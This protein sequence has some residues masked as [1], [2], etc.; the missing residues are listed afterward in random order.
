GT[1][2]SGTL[3]CGG[4]TAN[5]TSLFN[6]ALGATN[7]ANNGMFRVNGNL[8]LD[9]TLSLTDLGGMGV[10]VYTN[11][12]Y[13]GTL[14]SNGLAISGGPMGS[15][16]VV[17]TGTPHYVLM[18]VL[19]GSL[20]P[21][22]GDGVPMDSVSPLALSW[23]EMVGAT[24][25]DV[26]L[27]TASNEVFSATTSTA[28]IYQGRTNALTLNVANLLP[29]TT[30][31]W[32]ADGW[33]ANGTVT[34]GAVWS[35]TTGAAMADLMQDTWVATDA[36]NRT[37]PGVAECGSPRT[38]QPIGIFYFLWHTTNGLGTDGPRDNT[39]EIQRLG[40]Y[41][42]PH[43]PWADN[44]LWMSGG[45]GR[46][47]YWSEPGNGYYSG[48]DEWVIRRHIALLEA[49][50]VDVL[51]FDTTNGHPETQAPT[52][53]KIMAVIRKMRMEGT[54]VHLK[55]FHYTHATSPAT[56]TWLYNNFYK[57]G[58]Y[59]DLWFT[60]QGKPFI[61]GYPDATVSSEVLNYFT[62]RTG[63]A[64]GSSLPA[65]E[66]QWI[67]TP[68]R[69][70]YGFDA[71]TDIAE[72]MPVTCGGWANGN[73]GRS[74]ANGSQSGYNNAHLS[75]GRTEGLGL[76][77]NEQ[78]FQGLKV[79]P[80][81]LWVL[82]WNEWW[83]GAWN[84]GSTCYTHLLADCCDTGNR[85]FVDNY[86]AEYSRDIEPV[87][88]GFTDN[89]YYQL[90]RY[91]RQRKGVRPV[92]AAS[93]PK[94]INLAGDFSDW[95]DVGPEF[96]DLPGDTLS[97]NWPTTFGN[98]PNYT[99]NSG[100]NDLTLMK[101]ARDA[102]N[103]YF[104]AQ[105][106]SNLTSYTGSNWMTL[107]VDID[108]NHTTGWEGYD[109]AVNLGPRTSTA[110]TLSQNTT[111]TN[112]WTWTT[113]RSDIAFKVSGN[114]LMLAIPRASLGL[115]ADPLK[116]DFHW[117]DNFQTNDI[118]DFGTDGDSAPDRRFN[119]RY[120]TVTNTEVVLLADDFEAGKQGL[121]AETWTNGSQWNLTAASPYSGSSCAVGSYA[122]SGQSNLIAR[123]STLGYGSFRL[124]F[125][126]KLTNV[127]NAQNLQISYFCTNGWVP[128]R[129]LSRDEFYPASQAWSYDERQ[130]VWLNFT[131]ARCNTGPD[132][133][134]FTT[135]FAFRID[136]G[137]LTVAGQ[138]VFIDAVNL[139]ADTEIPAAV[140]AQ[141]WKTCDIGN[142]GNAGYVTTNSTTF[143]VSGSGF[144]IW[145]NGDAFRLLYQTRSGDGQLTARVTGITPTDPWAKAGV[146]IRESL[147]SGARHALMAFTSSNGVAFQQRAVSL[148]A[149]ATTAG[150]SSLAPPYWLRI[151]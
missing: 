134:F 131:D 82:G 127:L 22:A 139:A 126:Y 44:P 57:L 137:G 100:R 115:G 121:W 48:D 108:Q 109:Y 77:F 47:W 14:V 9:G 147:D 88:G 61:I 145:N 136:A 59:R 40:G 53:L 7:N 150:G 99:N 25:Y 122:A 26:Y 5:A 11:F 83:A 21:A 13:S 2:G 32:R 24:N 71:R 67:D 114:Q 123:V 68:V 73:L 106:N 70:D 84:S 1:A 125:H 110:T 62:W 151:V 10:G 74:Y 94:S 69:Q 37:L 15:T 79:D 117:A 93:G 66:W 87:K 90:V 80:Q 86:N 78:A 148:G 51:G 146:M 76:Q 17:D 91:A 96:R 19:A 72:Q 111:T 28:G 16:V 128:I 142:A 105:C 58:L 103:L 54:P 30:Y 119:Y 97:R 138:S 8:T 89:Y 135:N 34:K 12:Y 116:F 144:D 36:L 132:A 3:T 64:N 60:W 6:L 143:T 35:F 29:N 129:Q 49:A 95:S 18:R 31:Y 112:G 41:T 43:N 20:S 55:T 75:T 118:A 140:P 38:N 46:S 104:L 124:N 98:L 27:G 56:V 52:Y 85:Y 120:I 33:A 141:T 65:D 102:N 130:N 63:W 4:L 42:D 39:K 92:P 50:G 133:R 23:F 101:V 45:N 113:V 149:S 81:F 107:F